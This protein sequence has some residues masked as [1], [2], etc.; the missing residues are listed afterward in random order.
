MTIRPAK[1]DRPVRRKAPSDSE[2]RFQFLVTIGF[3][4]IVASVVVILIGSVALGYYNSHLKPIA[5][6]GGVG[7][8]RDDW[9]ARVDL[10]NFRIGRAESD[11]R[12]ALAA[13][14]IDQATADDRTS[15]LTTA[16]ND[17]ENQS[18]NDL[19]DLNYEA[20]LAA[21]KGITVSDAD[22]DA[23]IALEGSTQERR[24]IEAIFVA[25]DTSTS[26]GSTT[27]AEDQAALASAQ[28]AVT[29]IGSGMP[30]AQAAQIYST[31]SSNATGGEY[32]IITAQNTTDAAWVKALFALPVG[33]TTD[34]I[35]GADGIYR[36]GRVTQIL[37]GSVDPTFLPTL[38][39]NVSLATYRANVK[40][41]K[42]AT[43][44]SDKVTS[45]ATSAQVDQVHLAEIDV[46]GTPGDDS[47][48]EGEIRASH[49]LYS[50]NHDSQGA[51]ALDPS[52]PAWA[53]ALASA[54]ATADKMKAIT[55][56]TQREAAFAALA[57]TDSDDTS[58]G[59]QG[60]DLGWFVHTC[61]TDAASTCSA[62]VA[63]FADP[64]FSNKALQVGDIVGPVKSAF[65]YHVIMFMGRRE[66][67]DQR[68]QD[69]ENALSVTGAD[70]AT[71][72]KAH[73]E[74][75]SAANGGDLGW[76]VK[77]QVPTE[78]ADIVFGTIPGQVTKAIT[79]TDGYHIY[80]VIE[81]G[82][83]ALDPNQVSLI[84]G[85]AFSDYYSAAKSA[86]VA[87]GTIWTDPAVLSPA[88]PSPS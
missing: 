34:I 35:K 63:E 55:D 79:E 58:S 21:S 52:D 5:T 85:S 60:G 1:T 82:P 83:R 19:I 66:S 46:L 59:A 13:G 50:P 30:W 78:A 65:G 23:A 28:A 33:G 42:A 53:T 76:M 3:I 36:I 75:D 71:V 54:Q 32:G 12:E 20:E 41:E 16:Q 38:E 61:A 48:G 80:H 10:T 39:Q 45:D 29:A 47:T 43:E 73:S 81:R 40:L 18:L 77:Q 26:L 70:F 87:D 68:L 14:L 17:V 49:I 25:P 84:T 8:T 31:D 57:K 6:V 72:A 24:Q 88:S 44:L 56:V 64:L 69:V 22:V 15:T 37:P 27:P 4:V 86:A 51:A 11:V 62:M 7:I 2:D 67:T 9:S 74:G